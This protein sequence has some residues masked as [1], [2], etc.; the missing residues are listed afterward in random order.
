MLATSVWRREA[1]ELSGRK[2]HFAL[3]AAV[4]LALALPLLGGPALVPQATLYTTLIVTTTVLQSGAR[5]HYLIRSG[6]AQRMAR[7]PASPYKL[8]LS[9]VLVRA[10]IALLR[11]LPLLL[12]LEWRYQAPPHLW[13]ALLALAAPAMVA[14]ELTGGLAGSLARSAG[15]VWLYS[16]VLALPAL[17]LSGVFGPETEPLG[18]QYVIAQILPFTFLHRAVLQLVRPFPGPIPGTSIGPAMWAA[19]GWVGISLAFLK[20]RLERDR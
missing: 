16:L 20:G 18:I 17:F 4:P 5:A 10:V 9:T 19:V 15:E 3:E 14:S 6:L 11:L 2:A 1:L 13:L 12:A 8:F 7:T